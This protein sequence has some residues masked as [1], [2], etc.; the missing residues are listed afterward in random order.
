MVLHLD[1]YL[2]STGY[3]DQCQKALQ[4]KELTCTHNR[5]CTCLCFSLLRKI[6]HDMKSQ[7]ET[8]EDVRQHEELNDIELNVLGYI[9]GA[10]IHHVSKHMKLSVERKLLGKITGLKGF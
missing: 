2:K 9:S 5:V 1:T 7:N 3:K 4:L 6:V 10:C 8:T